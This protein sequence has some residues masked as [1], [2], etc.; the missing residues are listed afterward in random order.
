MCC[1][2]RHLSEAG[3]HTR[4]AP[5]RKP[6]RSSRRICTRHAHRVRD[7]GEAVR[8]SVLCGRKNCPSWTIVNSIV[9]L[10]HNLA[11]MSQSD[12]RPSE[13]HIASHDASR[14][15]SSVLRWPYSCS[16]CPG[17]SPGPANATDRCHSTTLAP[18]SMQDMDAHVPLSSA[19]M[20][21]T[22]SKDVLAWGGVAALASC[23]H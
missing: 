17:E 22:R 1:R 8:L 19:H 15:C 5:R 23:A 16:C 13:M 21:H 10:L 18:D 12:P 7:K 3:C 14:A 2:H 4:C 11:I 9:T 6:A 20:L